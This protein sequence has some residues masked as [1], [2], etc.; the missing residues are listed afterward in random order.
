MPFY[1]IQMLRRVRTQNL[2]F[3]HLYRLLAVGYYNY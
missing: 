2:F 1:A 3:F